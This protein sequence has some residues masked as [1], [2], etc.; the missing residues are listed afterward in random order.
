MK[1]AFRWLLLPLLLAG[2]A[3]GPQPPSPSA[4]D[5]PALEVVTQ[6]EEYALDKVV[7]VRLVNLHGDIRV[8]FHGAA[9][10]SLHATVQRIGEHPVDPEFRVAR[11]GDRWSLEVHYRGEERWREP[12]HAQ[13]RVDFGIWLPHGTHIDAQTGDGAVQIRRARGALKVR[14]GSGA[15]QASGQ[16]D[17]DIESNSGAIIARQETGQWTRSARV[18]SESGRILAAVPAFADIHLVA[19]A[20]GVISVEPGLPAPQA[21][22]DGGMQLDARFGAALRALEIRTSADISLVPVLKVEPR[23]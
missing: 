17:L 2:C 6:V 19:R 15:I 4:A 12:G 13:G 14:T 1:R 18:V 8:R 20:G 16:S 23:R 10:A 22:A 5:A 9:V 7:A 21:S 3:A 11:D